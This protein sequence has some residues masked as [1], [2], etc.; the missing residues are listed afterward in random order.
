MLDYDTNLEGYR[1]NLTEEQLGNAPSLSSDPGRDLSDR[2]REQ[3]LHDYYQVT[4]YWL[5]P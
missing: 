1:T 4:Y 2:E 5:I 3:D